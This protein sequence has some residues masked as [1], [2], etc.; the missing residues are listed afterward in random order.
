MRASAQ[1]A[2]TGSQARVATASA[3]QALIVTISASSAPT[4]SG[5]QCAATASYSSAGTRVSATRVTTSVKRERRALALGEERRLVPDGDGV[6]PLGGLAGRGGVGAVHVD[7]VGAAVD[8]R[9]AQ[10][11][12]VAQP[13]READP[14]ELA[15][16]AGV[17]VAHRLAERRDGGVD[18]EAGGDPVQG[19]WVVVMPSR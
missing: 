7:A 9:G 13:G 16:G 17:E 19:V 12:Q 3:F 18:V 11:H 10:P 5:D 4:S 6:D 15:R 1:S 2:R 14:V 8:L